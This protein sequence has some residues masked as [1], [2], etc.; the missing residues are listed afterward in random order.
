M[1]PD[2]DLVEAL[3][4]SLEGRLEDFKLYLDGR[5]SEMDRKFKSLEND[6]GR[7]DRTVR[8]IETQPVPYGRPKT[9]LSATEVHSVSAPIRKGQGYV[10]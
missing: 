6:L 9:F 7:V 3:T 1:N 8:A 10:G 5:F 4:A 2:Q